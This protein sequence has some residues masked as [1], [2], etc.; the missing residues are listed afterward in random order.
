MEIT[1][2][3]VKELRQHTGAGLMD[4]KAALKES[5]GDIDKAMEYLRIKGLAKAQKK[6]ERETSEGTVLSYIHP[7]SR[8][9]VLVQVNCETDF[10][11]RTD[12]F[13]A[14]SRDVAMQIA[15]TSPMSLD[16]DGVP[17]EAVS[18]EREVYRT[19][20]ME[21]KKPEAVVEKIIDG[22]LE[23]YYSE[24][25]LMDQPFIKDDSKTVRDLLNELVAKLG[26]NIRVARFARFQIGN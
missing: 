8:I 5:S 21:Q 13:Q 24:V 19:Q 26:E 6:S 2:A 10:V 14:F 25:T 9:G 20:A 11:A 22:R 18:K 16:R 3:M 12:E 7:G 4:C 1:A 15:A 17:E 23:K